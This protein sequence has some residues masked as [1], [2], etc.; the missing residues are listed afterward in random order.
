ML[1]FFKEL[2]LI[3]RFKY[4][5]SFFN[6]KSSIL[7]VLWEIQTMYMYSDSTSDSHDSMSPPKLGETQRVTNTD[8]IETCQ[9][10]EKE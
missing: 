6:S 10:G 1:M 5:K 9:G 3:H 4:T 8:W 7:G 2:T